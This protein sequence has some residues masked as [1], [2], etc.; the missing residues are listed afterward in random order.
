MVGGEQK[1]RRQHPEVIFQ[2]DVNTWD[3]A[4]SAWDSQ[5]AI[6]V[7]ITWPSISDIY[8]DSMTVF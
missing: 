6:T 7:L 5:S 3:T 2:K 1:N 8:E 4:W